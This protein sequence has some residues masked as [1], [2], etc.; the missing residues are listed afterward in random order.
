MSISWYLKRFASQF[1]IVTSK[2]ILTG[3]THRCLP[4][5]RFSFSANTLHK[6]K[7]NNIKW[8]PVCIISS[9]SRKQNYAYAAKLIA[10]ERLQQKWK[11]HQENRIHSTKNKWS[12][13]INTKKIVEFVVV[14]FIETV[15]YWRSYYC[16]SLAL[17]LNL[18]ASFSKLLIVSIFKTCLYNGQA[19]VHRNVS[20]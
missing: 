11:F 20:R 14:V 17:Q 7:A 13:P 16:Q 15:H 1:L 19:I 12:F 18:E 2:R 10:V 3:S 6:N 4:L 8:T 5:R 9:T